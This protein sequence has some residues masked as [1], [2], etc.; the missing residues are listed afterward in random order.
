M[1]RLTTSL[2]YLLA[3]LGVRLG[4]LFT[5]RIAPYGLTLYNYR[6]LAALSERP[7]QKL[8]EI[9]EMTTIDLSTMSRLIGS[10]VKMGLVSRVRLPN[11]ERTVRINLTERGETLARQLIKEALHYED[12]VISRLEP[13]MIKKLKVDLVKI[14][15]SLDVLEAELV[16]RRGHVDHGTS[17]RFTRSGDSVAPNEVDVSGGAASARVRS[18]RGR[19][20]RVRDH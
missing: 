15:D 19:R 8:S 7:D 4:V 14:F 12:V 20:R 6:V 9:S 3:R 18:T 2:P 10:M 5:R 16:K 11:D 17:A 1:Y 13:S